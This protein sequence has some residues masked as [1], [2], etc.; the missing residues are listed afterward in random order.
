MNQPSSNRAKYG[1]TFVALLSVVV[2][3]AYTWWPQR[4]ELPEGFAFANG[5]I[6]ATEVDVATK[7]PGRLATVK[8]REGDY[9]AGNDVLAQ[10]DTRT[11][12]AQLKVARAELERAEQNREYA[13]AMVV[14]RQSELSLA[15]KHLDRTGQ[16]MQQGHVSKEQIDR[17]RNALTSAGAALKA[18]EIGV[19]EAEAAIEAA[20]AQVEGITVNLEDS[21]LTAPIA[22]RVLYRLA[23][24]GE[25]IPAGGKVLTMLDLQDVYMTIFLPT[26]M[27]SQLGIG[28]EARIILDAWPQYV[29][30]AEVSYVSPQA[31]FTPKMVETQDE[32]EKLMFRVKVRIAPDLLQQYEEKVKV[33]VP[34]E[35]Y[36]RADSRQSWP[37]KLQVKLPQ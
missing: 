21:Q 25:V 24:P 27:A 7:L 15:Q 22:G 17:D 32:R 36:V 6:E 13:K 30:P 11:I 18:A 31:Q 3:A 4:G 19:T 20:K 35:A 34:G 14:Q 29:I 2:I 26:Q 9:V 8:V 5:R 16:L 1:L 33:G 37:E 28:D 23:E 12:D 10:L